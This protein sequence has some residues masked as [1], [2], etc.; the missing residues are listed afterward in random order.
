MKLFLFFS[1]FKE[2]NLILFNA[3]PQLQLNVDAENTL[4]NHEQI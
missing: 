1:V 3:I 4:S 2:M